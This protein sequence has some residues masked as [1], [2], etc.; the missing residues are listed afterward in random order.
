MSVVELAAKSFWNF[1]DA[2]GFTFIANKKNFCTF[3]KDGRL[4]IQS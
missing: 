2:F 1:K 3:D 4:E